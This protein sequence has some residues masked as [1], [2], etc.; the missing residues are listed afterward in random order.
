MKVVS[1]GANLSKLFYSAMGRFYS[2]MEQNLA[3]DFIQK[4]ALHSSTTVVQR[5]IHI[6]IYPHQFDLLHPDFTLSP[7]ICIQYNCTRNVL[8]KHKW[9][10]SLHST[11][12]SAYRLS[13]SYNN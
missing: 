11:K 1:L 3:A 4:V 10:A 12:L 2:Y 9:R 7:I 13:F 8:C 6:Y 5:W